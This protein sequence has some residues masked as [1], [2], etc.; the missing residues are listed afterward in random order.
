MKTSTD[1]I[2]TTHVGSMPR[3]QYVVDQLFAQDRDEQY[4]QAEFDRV[5][6]QAVR[7]VAQRQVEAGV[8]VI[9]DGEMS[10][11]SY[12]TYMR[13]RFTGF[14]IADVPRA[15]PQDLDDFPAY[16]QRLAEAG[17]TPKYHRP[18]VRDAITIKDLAPLEKDIDNL[19]AAQAAAGASEAFMNSASPGVVSGFQPNEYY[20]TTEEYLWALAEV[21]K[22]EYEKINEAGLLLQV[23]CPDLAMGWHI[24][25]RDLDIAA[26]KKAAAAQVE[27]LNYALSNVPAERARLHLCWGNYEGPHHHDVDLAEIVD[28][29][30]AAKPQAIQFEAANPRHQHE[31]QVWAQAN[32]PDDKILIPGALDTTTNFI[33][34][35]RLVAER[36]ER[37]ANIVGRERVIAGTDCGFGT[38]AGFGAIHPDIAYAKLRSLAEGARIASERL[39]S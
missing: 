21:L 23:D 7:E 29:V 3:P 19:L 17:G 14:E 27:A 11:I 15:T 20:A 16:K 34:H 24:L 36:I 30:L 18:V 28:I 22:V 9:S 6:R 38:F 39:W 10:K 8:D 5:M 4:D 2:L 25:F 31:W 33:E 13:H 37:F 12:V 32:I 26:F 35:P 1:R